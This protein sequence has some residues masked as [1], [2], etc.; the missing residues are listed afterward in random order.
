ME[1]VGSD[2]HLNLPPQC[3]HWSPTQPGLHTQWPVDVLHCPFIHGLSHSF[4]SVIVGS[5]RSSP[6]AEK[7]SSVW[8]I[9]A[10]PPTS[11]SPLVR[12]RMQAGRRIAPSILQKDGYCSKQ[13]RTTSPLL[14]GFECDRH[15]FSSSVE[16]W[17]RLLPISL[18][19][20]ILISFLHYIF[21]GKWRTDCRCHE[22]IYFIMGLSMKAPSGLLWGLAIVW[23]FCGR[24]LSLKQYLTHPYSTHTL[25]HHTHTTTTNITHTPQQTHPYQM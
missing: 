6:K 15:W 17:E 2:S 13:V 20:L 23:E 12:L 10:R 22:D 21:P 9:E 11:T 16:I 14:V 1:V 24:Q 4:A 7:M 25:T 3:W 19:F 5:P 8:S 18:L